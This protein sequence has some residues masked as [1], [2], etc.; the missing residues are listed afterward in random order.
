MIG[1]GNDLGLLHAKSSLQAILVSLLS[2]KNRVP[3]NKIQQ[4]WN[5]NTKV[6]FQENVF[7]YDTVRQNSIHFVKASLKRNYQ[8]DTIFVTCYTDYCNFVQLGS[9][10]CNF[11]TTFQIT[12]ICQSWNY[13]I[14]ISAWLILLRGEDTDVSAWPGDAIWRPWSG[15]TIAQLM[16]YRL[17][18]QSPCVNQCR[19]NSHW[20]V[21][22]AFT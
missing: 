11:L 2:M 21:S 19:L 18:I 12:L 4:N 1:L 10:E 8:F 7:E 16:P 9:T 15:S 6:F 3:K 20:W 5:P 13:W 22:V 17:M 14:T